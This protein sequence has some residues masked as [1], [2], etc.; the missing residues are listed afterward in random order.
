MLYAAFFSTPCEPKAMLTELH[1][2]YLSIS[3]IEYD[4]R[5]HVVCVI[6]SAYGSTDSVISQ[7]LE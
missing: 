6:Y 1:N 3:T 7:M 2:Y 4:F 5:E